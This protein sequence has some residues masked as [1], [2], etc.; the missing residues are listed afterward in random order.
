MS[1]QD[2]K[3]KILGLKLM[4]DL[5]EISQ[6]EYI[7]EERRYRYLISNV[8]NMYIENNINDFQKHGVFV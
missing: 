6:D 2:L 1:V 5:G 7:K 8:D 4:Y 3:I